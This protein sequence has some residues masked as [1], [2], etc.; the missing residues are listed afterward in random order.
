MTT[1]KPESLDEAL[2]RPG[3]VD[4]QVGFTN[5]TRAQAAELF[6]RMYE[7]DKSHRRATT[8]VQPD[9]ATAT[10]TTT[11]DTTAEK[12]P[13]ED[14]ANGVVAADGRPIEPTP[15]ASSDEDEDEDDEDKDSCATPTPPTSTA[16]ELAHDERLD[17]T[18]SEL[19]SIARA[20]AAKVPDGAFSP[21]E[22]QGFLLKRKKN[23]RRAL[24]EADK[25]IAAMLEQKASKTKILQVQ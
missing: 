6:E 9:T 10:T 4:L 20:F 24:A 15:P 23:P 3:R 19:R 18:A 13:Q 12:P 1:N 17:M 21:A 5:A 8:A 2:I 16:A 22:I 25:W 7:A 14:V 11:P